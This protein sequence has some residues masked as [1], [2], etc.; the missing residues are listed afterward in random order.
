MIRCGLRAALVGAALV[1]VPLAACSNDGT[2]P[3]S[4]GTCEEL[5]S[6]AADVAR[7][8]VLDLSG[9]TQAD[10]EAKNREDPFA[11]LLQPFAAY[12]LRA[13]ELGCDQGELVRLACREYRG[14]EPT[15]P[16]AEEFLTYV[17]DRCR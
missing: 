3:Q 9:L 12:E 7:Q 16:V 13:T 17:D 15:G 2:G 14:I 10:L 6:D 4:A 8:V 11:M 5:V 1:S